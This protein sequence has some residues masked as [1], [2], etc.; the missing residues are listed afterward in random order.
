VTH[1]RANCLNRTFT[2][3]ASNGRRKLTLNINKK[4]KLFL[5]A[6]YQRSEINQ[7]ACE[8]HQSEILGGRST[9]ALSFVFPRISSVLRLR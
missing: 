2:H 5:A 4:E 9:I 1:P 3:S 8:I 7:P 6:M